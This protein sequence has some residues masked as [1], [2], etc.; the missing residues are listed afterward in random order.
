MSI[1]T[2]L[3]QVLF[4]YTC[5]L[6]AENAAPQTKD[7]CY[8]CEL[9]LPS[10]QT[11]CVQCCLQLTGTASV[12]GHCLQQPPAYNRMFALSDYAEPMDRIIT[13]AKFHQKLFYTRV[14]GELL[15]EQI[16]KKYAGL[17]LPTYLLPVPLHPRRLKERGYNQAL[18]IAKITAKKLHLPINLACS[19]VKATL[20]QSS[21]AH[22]ERNKNIKNAFQLIRPITARHVAIIDD[23]VTTGQTVDAMSQVLRLSGVEQIDIWCCART[24]L[25]T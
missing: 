23:V 4:P 5:I 1:L 3:Q 13:A 18:E 9:S 6:C 7:L 24:Q 25:N 17:T 14:L 16:Q 12:C 10:L 11:V 15:A 20:P 22:S 21:L 19:R 2:R 8:D